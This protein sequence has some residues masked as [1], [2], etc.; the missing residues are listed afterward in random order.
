MFKKLINF[1]KRL[2]GF[3]K[4]TPNVTPTTPTITPTIFEELYYYTAEQ[5]ETGHV[6]TVGSFQR[7][8]VGNIFFLNNRENTGCYR[9]TGGSS[10]GN[11]KLSRKIRVFDDCVPC[12]DGLGK[13]PNFPGDM[14]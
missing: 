13:D 5:C 10:E 1:I 2:F 7:L 8:V 9:V 6:E 14:L 11:K 3:N 4:S 12:S